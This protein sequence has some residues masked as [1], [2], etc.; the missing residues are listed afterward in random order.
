M[1]LRR[2][3]LTLLALAALGAPAIA[4]GCQAD[5]DPPTLINTLRVLAVSVDNP[6]PQPGDEVTFTM[7]YHDGYPGPEEGPRPVQILWLGGCF[8]PPGEQYFACYEQIAELFA[9]VASG[10]APPEEYFAAGIGLDTFT[11]PIPED[12]ISSRPA[13]EVGPHYGIGY[14]FFAACAGN[15]RPVTDPGGKAG[16]FPFGCFD[17]EG[18]RLG[19]ESFVPGYTQIYSFAPLAPGEAPPTNANPQ[20]LG[21]TLDG[22]KIEEDFAKIPI[23]PPCP[24]TAEERRE[25]G[26][27]APVLADECTSYA[28]KAEVDPATV[29][30]VDPASTSID[31]DPLKEVVWVSYFA[32]QGNLTG[33][34]KLV[35]DAVVGYVDTYE[36]TWIPPAEPGVTTL[37]AVLRDARGGSSVLRRSI[38]V[39]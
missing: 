9:Q 7:T 31:G 27:G 4:S 3:I 2:P 10:G 39:E 37:W 5:F 32:D 11:M 8:N 26:C 16:A 25:V 12:I 22:A 14:V 15:L 18:R 19:A 24:I 29:A 6:Y 17:N 35:S 34:T 23:V 33:G 30:E 1:N 13:P 21:L 36:A 28:L 38:R 20:L